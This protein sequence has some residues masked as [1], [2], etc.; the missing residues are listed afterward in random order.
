MHL[1]AVVI[2]VLQNLRTMIDEVWERNDDREV[3]HF[4]QGCL[5]LSVEVGH[6]FDINI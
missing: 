3:L 4:Y 6:K 1:A 5:L 2:S